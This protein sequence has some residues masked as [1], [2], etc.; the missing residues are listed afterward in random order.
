MANESGDASC[1]TRKR[2]SLAQGR[3][4]PPD[5]LLV[6]LESRRHGV[7]GRP[8][9]AEFRAPAGEAHPRPEVAGAPALGGAQQGGDRPDDESPASDPRGQERQR[10]AQGDQQRAP[11]PRLGHAGHRDLRRQ[12]DAHQQG[13][14]DRR[15]RRDVAHDLVGPVRARVGQ[16]GGRVRVEHPAEALAHRL[17]HELRARDADDEGPVAVRDPER[18]P[19]RHGLARVPLL[20]QR[21]VDA[22]ADDARHPA[23][24]AAERQGDRQDATPGEPAS[25]VLADVEP[26]GG[27]RRPEPRAPGAVHPARRQAAFRAEPAPRQVGGA[28]PGV[29]AQVMA[30]PGHEPV[31]G[32]PVARAHRGRVRE[33]EE[34]RLRPTKDAVQLA[35]GEPG[36]AQRLGVRFGLEVAAQREAVIKLDRRRRQHR[37]EHEEV[38]AAHEAHRAA[39]GRVGSIGAG[40]KRFG[41][42]AAVGV[43]IPWAGARAWPGGRSSA[44][45]KHS[46]HVPPAE[47]APGAETKGA[48]GRVHPLI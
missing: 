38:Q 30:Q 48:V 16:R 42:I 35:G 46:C 5:L 11:P 32:G 1:A 2:S 14:I 41:S 18:R 33:R 15:G 20:E 26:A 7:E 4:R 37:D 40:Q 6:R 12:A 31:T 13:L 44:A 27:D 22:Q 25:G 3:E 29:A 17:A 9:L 10:D 28:Q 21:Q 36:Q 19:D 39:S 47:P 8:E 24:G 23:V 43:S 45:A 34:Q